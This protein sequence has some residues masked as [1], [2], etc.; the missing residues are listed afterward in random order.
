MATVIT[1][2]SMVSRGKLPPILETMLPL[3]LLEELR[4]VGNARGRIEEIRLRCGR[5]ASLTT[6][7]G[8]ILLD[9]VLDRGEMDRVVN[10]MC[11]GSLYAHR[12]SIAKGYLTLTG[13]IRVGICGRAAVE[14][15]KVIGVYDISG[16]NIRLPAPLRG[17]G[18]PVCRLLQERR[19]SEGILIYSPPGVGKTTLLRGIASRMA[20]GDHPMRVTVVDT[21]GELGYSLEERELCL[22]VLVGYPRALGIEIATRSLNSELIVC[23]EIGEGKEAE[24]IVSAQNCGVP[25]VASAHADNV[26][27]LLRRTGIRTLHR[28]RIFGQYVGIRRRV[29]GGDYIYTVT[30]WEEADGILQNSG[31]ADPRR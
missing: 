22:D 20:S 5:R 24:A 1:P 21:R 12:D 31:S 17:V 2:S 4:R 3:F 30:D 6:Q 28:A 7:S 26:E 9:S 27:G 16:L 23:D 29:G 8:N 19:G 15:R 25:F 14:D 18:A 11:D 10:A 13:G